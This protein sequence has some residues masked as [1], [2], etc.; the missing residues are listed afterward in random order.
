MKRKPFARLTSLLSR[1][2]GLSHTSH[3]FA[4][5]QEAKRYG[6]LHPEQLREMLLR[7]LN[8]L[9]EQHKTFQ[10]TWAKAFQN[11]ESVLTQAKD[12]EL[13]EALNSVHEDLSLI[14]RS[15]FRSELAGWSD[16]ELL[17]EL[18]EWERMKSFHGGGAAKE[19]MRRERQE[20]L[21][22]ELRIRG[23]LNERPARDDV[24]QPTHATRPAA[25]I[26]EPPAITPVIRE[27]VD[28]E[29]AFREWDEIF[30]GMVDEEAAFW[31]AACDHMHE[32]GTMGAH[33]VPVLK[34]HRRA[35]A[36]K[37]RQSRMSGMRPAI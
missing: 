29:T 3:V 13:R 16:R 37:R 18:N 32:T 17:D 21:S 22:S 19:Q 25:Y 5:E 2:R 23:A 6:R 24:R 7:E 8:F 10:R 28:A 30:A 35:Q 27:S 34:R 1:F 36:E 12:A 26:H 14:R 31:Q 11:I 4:T 20:M 33:S 15:L 9:K